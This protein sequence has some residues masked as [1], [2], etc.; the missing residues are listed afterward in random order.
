[1]QALVK[2]ALG[3]GNM[4]IRDMPEPGPAPGQ[5][6]IAVHGCGICGSDLHVFHQTIGIPMAPPVI[7]GHE[8]SGTIVELGEGVES[9]GVGDR[10]TVEPSASICGRCR[11]CRQ[12]NYNLCPDRR[13]IGYR[14]DGGFAPYVVVP[15]RTLHRL[16]ANVTFESGAL[17]EPLACCVH[18]VIERTQI[19]AGDFVAITGPGSIGLLAL[20]VAKAE[21]GIVCMLG[22]GNDGHRLQKARELGAAYTINVDEQDAT[23]EIAKLTGGYG[24]DVVLEASGAAPAG[25]MALEIVRKQGKF[26]QMGLYPGPIEIDFS[27]IAYREISVTGFMAQKRS[28]WKRAIKLMEHGLIDPGKIIS[29]CLPLADWQH[30]FGMFERKE[31]LKILLQ[32][33]PG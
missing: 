20:M 23:R 24:A 13:V 27:Q 9:F 1:M 26:T 5:V 21:G 8:F 16:P 12:E 29:H 10:V 22:T 25:R 4:E 14:W 28:A 30:A 18:G 33:S 2:Y 17:T 3:H 31:S 11:Y 6:K 32:P 7:T 19:S 15:T